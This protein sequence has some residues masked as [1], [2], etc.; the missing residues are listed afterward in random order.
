MSV[1]RTTDFIYALRIIT[2]LTTPWEK[3]TAFKLGI[4]DKDGNVLRKYKDLRSSEEKDAYTY[5]HRMVFNMKRMLQTVPGGKSWVAAA[6]A[7]FL[8]L[9]ENLEELGLEEADW[10]LIEEAIFNLGEETPANVSGSEVST[11][12][13]KSISKKPLKRKPKL[14]V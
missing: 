3:Q 12:V 5:L 7:S 6:T 9:R 4:I 13:E 8:L 1:T 11:D 14:E 10:N 2:L